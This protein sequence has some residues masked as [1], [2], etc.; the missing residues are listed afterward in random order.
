MPKTFTEDERKMGHVH[1]SQGSR[2]TWP[3]IDDATMVVGGEKCTVISSR[4]GGPMRIK[5]AIEKYDSNHVSEQERQREKEWLKDQIRGAKAEI[6][7][8]QQRQAHE[9][10]ERDEFVAPDCIMAMIGF[11]YDRLY[12]R[13]PA[14]LVDEVLRER[15]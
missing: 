6:D 9:T 11:R 12:A 4:Q 7:S 2:P 14:R 5:Q 8:Q 10:N 3:N 15:R 13:F 1:S